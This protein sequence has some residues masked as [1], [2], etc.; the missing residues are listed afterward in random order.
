MDT[1]LIWDDALAS[2]RFNTTHPMN[3]RRLELTLELS[4]RLGLL[5][6]EHII[7]P[8]HASDDDLLLAHAPELIDAVRRVS[9]GEPFPAAQ[10]YGL[11]SED[12]PIAPG[13]H[14][15]AAHVAGATLTAADVVM[16]GRA[17]RAFSIAGGLHH[18][19]R[20]EAAGFCVYNDLAI[21][22]R[23]IQQQYNARVLYIDYDAHHGDGVQWIFYDDPTVLTLSYHESG[24]YLFPGTGFVDETGEGDGYG[25]SVNVPLD[26]HTEDASWESA[27]TSLVPDIARAFRPDVVVLQC[28]CDGHVL[29]PLT[30][31]RCTTGLFERM[32][33]LV[34]DIADEYCDGRLIATGGGGYAVHT[35]VPRAW[36]LVWA[37]L[38]GVTAQDRIPEEFQRMLRLESG[39]PVPTT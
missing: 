29:D 7:A 8:R 18:A 28:G 38:N 13:M 3:P 24:A 10:R 2:Y 30:H 37:V 5:G 36:T 31:L 9:A 20:A 16:S 22:I 27:F 12:V 14:E 15:M 32:T 17:R 1:A 11:G 33:K 25:Y 39:S 34:C 26:A 21:A 6:D 23:W 4:R 19:R 35:V